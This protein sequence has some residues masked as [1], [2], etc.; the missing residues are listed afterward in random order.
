MSSPPST[1]KEYSHGSSV[2]VR[3]I[4][5]STA[6]SQ[7]DSGVPSM[8]SDSTGTNP[9]PVHRSTVRCWTCRKRSATA[10]VGSAPASTTISAW[11][12]EFSDGSSAA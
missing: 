1:L 3:M 6:S 2:A 12:N 5:H 9:L 4:S 8:S 7:L 11:V 10:N